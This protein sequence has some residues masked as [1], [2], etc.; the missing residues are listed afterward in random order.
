M[1][2][3]KTSVTKRYY[4]EGVAY[5][6]TGFAYKRQV[7]FE[8]CRR[9]FVSTLL[10][11]ETRR[12]SKAS[13]KIGLPDEFGEGLARH[14]FPSLVSFSA[15]TGKKGDMLDEKEER[16]RELKTLTSG[17][18]T[19]FSPTSRSEGYVICDVNMETSRYEIYYMPHSLLSTAEINRQTTLSQ[20]WATNEAAI[21]ENQTAPRPRFSMRAFIKKNEIK[22]DFVGTL[23][24]ASEM[25]SVKRDIG[26]FWQEKIEKAIFGEGP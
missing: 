2:R 17:G 5:E 15:K 20:Q 25:E 26:C 24:E 3:K 19:S 11:N 4:Y 9:Q 18:P 14:H 23:F 10:A 1:P 16:L 13:R 12:I 21:A 8:D 6:L 7:T 22:P